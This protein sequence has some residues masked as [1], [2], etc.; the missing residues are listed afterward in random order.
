MNVEVTIR[1][2]VDINTHINKYVNASVLLNGLVVSSLCP[3]IVEI[4][5]LDGGYPNDNTYAPI[6][7]NGLTGISGG[8][9]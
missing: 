3:P 7:A 2:D 1:K 8:T 9:P 5:S 6:N 4:D